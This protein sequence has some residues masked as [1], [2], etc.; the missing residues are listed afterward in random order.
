MLSAARIIHATRN[1]GDITIPPLPYPLPPNYMTN[2]KCRNRQENQNV[3]LT[4][5]PMRE[6]I[7]L[8][9]DLYPRYR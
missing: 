5:N 9:L 1:T 8:K 7:Q 3:L 2:W 4:G 6:W